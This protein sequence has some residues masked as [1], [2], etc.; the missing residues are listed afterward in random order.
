MARGQLR[1]DGVETSFACESSTGAGQCSNSELRVAMTVR[2]DVEFD[3]R[4]ELPDGTF[5]AWQ[6]FSID[7][8]RGEYSSATCC[9]DY[10][11][12][13]VRVVVPEAARIDASAPVPSEGGGPPE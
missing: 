4:F 3:V 2:D 11:A 9:Q 1:V 5:T 13:P 12:T 8:T 6:S 10:T 7:V